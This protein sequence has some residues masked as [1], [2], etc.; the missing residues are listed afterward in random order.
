MAKTVKEQ[1]DY[2]KKLKAEWEQAGSGAQKRM[3][4]IVISRETRKLKEMEKK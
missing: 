1:K 3:L 4:A 2:I